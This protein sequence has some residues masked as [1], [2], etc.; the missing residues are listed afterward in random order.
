MAAV[1]RR[2]ELNLYLDLS[3]TPIQGHL[4]RSDGSSQPFYGWMQLSQFIEDSLAQARQQ[5]KDRREDEA[6]P[7][8]RESSDA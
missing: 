8:G 5:A 6:A 2:L 3:A 7:T 4:A 1:T